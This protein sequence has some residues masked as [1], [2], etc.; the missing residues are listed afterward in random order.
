MPD[1]TPSGVVAARIRAVLVRAR[2]AHHH[3]H[4]TAAK[5]YAKPAAPPP[6]TT[7]ARATADSTGG[8]A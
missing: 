7:S 2:A 4:D 1:D 8:V 6:Q 3:A 5:T